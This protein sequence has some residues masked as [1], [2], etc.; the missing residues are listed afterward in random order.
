MN[1]TAGRCRLADASVRSRTP[2]ARRGVHV[3]E[4]GVMSWR[5]FCSI[6]ACAILLTAGA[7]A[8]YAST[9]VQPERPAEQWKEILT[10]RPGETEASTTR[11]IR[12]DICAAML[13]AH[14]GHSRADCVTHYTLKLVRD[15]DSKVG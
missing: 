7:T 10:L 9:P 13:A 5:R 8:A 12:A 11:P 6:V 3:A 4:E 15:T 1:A 14:P 2:N